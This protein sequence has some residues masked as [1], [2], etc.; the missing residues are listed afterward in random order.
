MAGVRGEHDAGYMHANRPFWLGQARSRRWSVLIT[1]GAA[2]IGMGAALA[3]AVLAYGLGSVLLTLL[4]LRA[5]DLGAVMVGAYWAAFA[6]KSTVFSDIVIEGL[7]YPFYLGLVGAILL[8]LLR[9]GLRVA[10]PLFWAQCIFFGMVFLSLLGYPE[11][12]DSAFIQKFIAMLICPAVMLAIQSRRGLSIVGAC[13][14]VAGVGIA[15]WVIV[16]SALGGFEYRGDVDV[17]QNIAA[18]VVGFSL[19]VA[20]GALIGANARSRSGYRL[21]LVLASG[22]MAYA[23][24]LLASR[25]MT[26]A[27]GVAVIAMFVH[28]A[29]RDRRVLR[30]AVLLLAVAGLGLLL[31]GGGG[32]LQRFEGESVSSAGDRTPIWAVTID[33]L[34][35]GN[36]AELAVGNGFNSSQKVVKDATAVHTSTHNAYLAMGYDY[37]LLGL[38]AFLAIHVL[39]LLRAARSDGP[40]ATLAI[41][42]VWLLLGANLT[43]TTPDDFTYWLALG[44]ALACVSVGIELQRRAA[45]TRLSHGS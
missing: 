42:T 13:G 18:F 32:L 31:P 30:V 40:Y 16:N 22:V 37:G 5:Q 3:P 38:L 26:I 12:V 19:A 33:A 9:G 28:A 8:A 35:D 43:T 21:A 44:Y 27:L 10:P 36:L 14:V 29:T 20:I 1:I 24:L 11:A 4:L 45:S 7:F 6:I 41:G 25:G 34:E 17:N 15:V 39:V 23:L 2:A